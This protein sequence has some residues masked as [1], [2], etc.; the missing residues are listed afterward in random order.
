MVMRSSDGGGSPEQDKVL[1]RS[2]AS[3]P[4]IGNT[5]SPPSG[6]NDYVIWVGQIADA[7][8]PWGK[9]PKQRDAQLRLFYPSENYLLSA[10]LTIAGRN[11]AF[12][13][14]LE[15]KSDK[16]V[17]MAQDMLL[18]SNRGLGWESYITKL[19]VDVESQDSGAFTEIIRA[20]DSPTAPVINFAH[21]DSGRCYATGDPDKPV[22]YRDRLDRFHSLKWYQ[23]WHHLEAPAPVENYQGPLYGLQ[24]CS[25]SRVLKAAQILKSIST[26]QD[27]KLSGRNE[28]AIHLIRG[29]DVKKI[30][31]ALM[32]TRALA[33]SQG[34]TR[35]IRP[36]MVG[37]HNPDAEVG[38][39]TI[40]LA[41]LPPG[42]DLETS[43]KWYISAMALAFNVDYQD[44]A[45]LPSGNLGSGQQSE[46]LHMK[47]RGKGP[48][49]FM[50]MVEHFMN[51]S[52]ILPEG[53]TFMFDEQDMQAESEEQTMKLSR[54]QER[55]ARVASTEIDAEAARQIALDAGD[56][57]QEIYD[58][59]EK[60]ANEAK[61]QADAEKKAQAEAAA[62][63]GIPPGALGAPKPA[64]GVP[65]VPKGPAPSGGGPADAQGTDNAAVTSS[66]E[67]VPPGRHEL[68]DAVLDPIEE[69]LTSV[70]R[71][72][73]GRIRDLTTEEENKA[74][75]TAAYARR[76][77]RVLRTITAKD[78]RGRPTQVLEEE[79]VQ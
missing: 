38:H 63:A 51:M 43:M 66:K 79:L 14:K 60:R 11:A 24:F 4:D 32:Q 78:D 59:L 53:V 9:A 31:D 42:F 12:S 8:M 41:S 57:T 3:T 10:L 75:D 50:K 28:S 33:D 70:S 39:D 22:I 71:R 27:E 29:I 18:N 56:L 73:T 13:W 61:T 76:P 45:P 15:G 62:A 64:F 34:L 23:V 46:V 69:I 26:Y 21:L 20:G 30:E 36:A 65:V 19:T 40:E 52:G 49:L 55:A 16:L 7:I 54:A 5:L 48:A 47:S 25:V 37:S 17:K 1:K 68:E 72:L 67:R 74:H 35:Y 2:V 6:S 44:F 77:R 58:D